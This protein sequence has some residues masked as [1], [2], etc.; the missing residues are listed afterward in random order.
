MGRRPKGW[1]LELNPLRAPWKPAESTFLSYTPHKRGSWGLYPPIPT[2][3][4]LRA[5]HGEVEAVNCAPDMGCKMALCP[6]A[7]GGRSWQLDGPVCTLVVKKGTQSIHYA[8]Y[9][10]LT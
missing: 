3:H 1:Q 10:S 9:S 8:D 5:A 6:Q 2:S 4:W 7:Q